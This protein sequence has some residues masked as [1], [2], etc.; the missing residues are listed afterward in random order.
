M[1]SDVVLRGRGL[2]PVM[3][4][5]SDARA[6]ANHWRAEAKPTAGMLTVASTTASTLTA[7]ID[8]VEQ[9]AEALDVCEAEA[10]GRLPFTDAERAPYLVTL[11]PKPEYL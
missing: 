11:Q 8:A 6:L 7:L 9:L 10:E 3:H 1:T 2:T 4:L 5:L